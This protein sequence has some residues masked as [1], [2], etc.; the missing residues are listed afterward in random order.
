MNKVDKWDIG[1][2]K[3]AP[4][5]LSKQNEVIKKTVLDELVKKVNV[6]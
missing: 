3:I 1:K 6:I 5:D 4:V 2:I